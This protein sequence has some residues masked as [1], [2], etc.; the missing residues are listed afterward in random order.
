MNADD[1]AQRLKRLNELGILDTRED[2]LFRELAVQALKLFPGTSIA[3]V[4][5]I[6]N[7][8]QWCKAIIGADV[9]EIPRDQSFCTHTIET[10]ELMV[11][12]DASK[13]PRFEGNPLVKLGPKVRFYAGVK[14]MSGVGAL[15]VIGQKPRQA[16]AS[17][18]AKLKKLAQLVDIQLMAYGTLNA[19]G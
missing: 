4:T 12:E 5:L 10:P 9:K 3:A 14:L 6:D 19:L 8:R 7:D 11:V 18:L 13:D 17:E 15:C 1:E 16:S 2:K